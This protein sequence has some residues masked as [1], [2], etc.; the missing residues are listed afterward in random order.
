[1]NTGNVRGLVRSWGLGAYLVLFGP[2]HMNATACLGGDTRGGAGP[3]LGVIAITVVDAESGHP[4]S[5]A[6]ISAK[7]VDGEHVHQ[8]VS[9]RDGRYV[10]N[11]IE[12]GTY[13]LKA[14]AHGYYPKEVPAQVEVRV[15]RVAE[16]EVSLRRQVVPLHEVVIS[17]GQLGVTHEEP[18][19]S[20]RLSRD[21]IHN[22]PQLGDDLFRSIATLPGLAADDYNAGF[23][24]RGGRSGEVLVL[25]DGAPLYEPFHIR[26]L[27]GVF[28]VVDTRVIG[29]I[30]LHPGGFTAEYG[31]RR[32]GVLNMRTLGAPEHSSHSVGISLSNARITS[33]G[34][35]DN[36][37]GEW[38]VSGRRGYI[39][40]LLRLLD[41]ADDLMPRYG[42]LL[43][44]VQYE[45]A[46]G[47]LVSAHL[48][49][50]NEDLRARE[51]TTG[52]ATSYGNNNYWIRWIANLGGGLTARTVL[53]TNRLTSARSLVHDDLHDLAVD[54]TDDR[55]FVGYS[56]RQDFELPVGDVALLRWGGDVRR[57][58]AS[59]DYERHLNTSG[60]DGGE[61]ISLPESTRVHADMDGDGLGVYFSPRFRVA[62]A[63]TLETGVRYDARSHT[64]DAVWSPRA[65]VV[66][67]A[68]P[69][70][71]LRAGWGVYHQSH[72]LFE[73]D[74]SDGDAEYHAAEQAEHRTLGLEHQIGVIA[75][76]AEAYERRMSSLRPRYENLM[77]LITIAPEAI[78]DRIRTEPTSGIARGLELYM[79]ARH[80]VVPV[81]WSAGYTLSQASEEVSGE[82]VPQER[83]QRH[84]LR[85]EVGYRPDARWDLS[86]AWQVRSGRP[87]TPVTVHTETL[88]DGFV[89]YEFEFGRI[90]SARL[91]PYHR[92]D[93]RAT[94]H[95]SVGAGR[96]SAFLDVFNAYGRENI[97]ASVEFPRRKSDGSLE[98][99]DFRVAFLPMLPS[100]GLTWTF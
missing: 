23:H 8:G 10:F 64:G 38:V 72:E 61:R 100:I 66:W 48:L 13:T 97:R 63:L 17:P 24:L 54:L 34:Q 15:G 51:A 18:G 42:D 47:H 80:S 19:R 82:I 45:I 76:R 85:A 36:G 83:D 11:G 32:T 77:G 7:A 21:E 53:A 25:L 20:L 14:D 26:D 78:D 55:E 68:L 37:R 95:F 49:R 35:F 89:H 31:D 69:N 74:A 9:W 65:N 62:S 40:V 33:T 27:G 22:R 88:S 44:K 16:V 28:S 98:V 70:T 84:A 81:Q 52:L 91:P 50:A 5:G 30:D 6:E 71:T 94:R 79:R 60:T 93:L 12:E 92:L 29:G 4:I 3:N 86:M 99:E 56:L 1:M 46:D 90:R 73:L 75:L 58:A 59:Y 57:G 39:D 67:T 43:A 96:L 87:Y 41:Q 2:L